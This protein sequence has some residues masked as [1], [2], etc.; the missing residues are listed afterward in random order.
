M[1]SLMEVRDMLALQGRMEAKQLSARLQTPQ[2]LIDAMLERMEDMGK[3][4]RISETSEGCLS[5]SCK[6]CPEGKAACRQEW[7]ALR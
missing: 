6:S 2:P 5:G 7:W 1:A 4:V 3:V